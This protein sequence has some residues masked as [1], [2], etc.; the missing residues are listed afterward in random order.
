M[1][2]LGK[3]LLF[4]NLL[5]AAGVAYLATQDWATRQNVTASALQYHLVLSGIPVASPAGTTADE[6]TVPFVAEM[7]GGYKTTSV[8]PAFLTAYFQGA[9]GGQQL[10]AGGETIASQVDEVKRVQAK[11]NSVL[12]GADP[13]GQLALLVG[14]ETADQT[15]VPTY[16][17]GWLTTLATTFDE[18][19]LVRRLAAYRASDG[20]AGREQAQ[21]KANLDRAKAIFEK[22]FAAVLNA[23]SEPLADAESNKLQS[24]S[25]KITAVGQKLRGL[26][27]QPMTD[28]ATLK[29]ATDEL[30]VARTEYLDV[31]ADLGTAAARGEPDRKKRI[32]HL[33]TFL[34][35][36]AEWQKRVALVIGLRTY[37]DAISEQSDRLARMATLAEAQILH[38]QQAFSAEYAILRSDAE[39][40]TL[41][42]TQ[43]Q[44]IRA[45]LDKQKTAD[46][47]AITVRNKY[48]T[49]RAAELTQVRADVTAALATQ[50]QAEQRLFTT[51]KQVG[52]TLQKNLEQEEQ[53][54]EFEVKAAAKY[55]GTQP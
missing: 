7:S 50:K 49:D 29:A 46:T 21:M 10:A 41:L 27:G 30:E 39:R 17:P 33:L 32:A 6:D 43:Q 51:Q 16:T 15:G 52:D 5:A 11:A 3:V 47:E 24:V 19:V 20:D 2:T 22:K 34:D 55:T 40:R 48:L 45:D 26:A 8:T 14:R 35:P 23:P 4:V 36:T 44:A 12:G 9:S 25:E 31:L 53:L 18:R 38:D 28:A 1:G 37:R 13:A 42:L 54:A